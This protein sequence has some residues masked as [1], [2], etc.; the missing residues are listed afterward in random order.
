MIRILALDLGLKT[1]AAVLSPDGALLSWLW[2]LPGK[3]SADHARFFQLAKSLLHALE[4]N[5]PI[6]LIAYE[7]L[8]FA[9][10]GPDALISYGG[11]RATVLLTAAGAGVPYLGIKPATWK[12]AAGLEAR[13]DAKDAL[14]AAMRRW[15][16]ASF[17]S[18][19]VAVARWIAVAASAKGVAW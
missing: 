3:T 16:A 2:R 17:E 1:G 7:E 6:G 8:H 15:P 13:T 10:G 19:D 18:P 5:A 11:L 4:E 12:R 9:G 14:A